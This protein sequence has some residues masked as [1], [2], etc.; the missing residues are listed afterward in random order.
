[1]Q[2]YWSIIFDMYSINKLTNSLRWLSKREKASFVQPTQSLTK[3]LVIRTTLGN[4]IKIILVG[5]L[6]CPSFYIAGSWDLY[7]MPTRQIKG[8][9][10]SILIPRQKA[11]FPRLFV[12]GFALPANAGCSGYHICICWYIFI[13][14]KAKTYILVMQLL[15]G[16]F[17]WKKCSFSASGL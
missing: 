7:I 1:M 9:L 8:P 3:F 2:W 10:L 5:T 17:E 16:I 13:S 14:R 4:A 11:P 6:H 12:P 15:P